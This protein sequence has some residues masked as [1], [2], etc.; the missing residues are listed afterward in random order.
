MLRGAAALLAAVMLSATVFA[1]TA[2]RHL[3]AADTVAGAN[4]FTFATPAGKTMRVW[5]W[6]PEKLR[7]DTPVLFVAHGVQR[8]ADRYFREWLP[9]AQ[10]HAAILVV[11][12]FDEKNFPGTSAYNHGNFRNRDGV[13]LSPDQWS[14]SV[15]EPLFDEVRRRTGSDANGYAIYGHSAGSQFVHRFVFFVPKARY[16]VA[17]AANAGSY[18]MPTFE[19]DFPFG[20]GKS[21]VTEAMLN[22]ALAK[23]VTVLLGSADN[24]PAHPNLPSQ[25]EAKAQGPHRLARGEAFFAAAQARAKAR[26]VTFGWKLRFVQ[27]V[28]HDN[29]KMAEASAGLIFRKQ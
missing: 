12:E 21:P 6:Q 2:A 4:S 23:P 28:G 5:L 11:P 13:F 10:R 29:G 19:V 16:T 25:P 8:D 9:Y 7:K 15:I 14:Y 20:F 27:D 1:A 18:A 24:D 3:R 17:V 22:A 26:N